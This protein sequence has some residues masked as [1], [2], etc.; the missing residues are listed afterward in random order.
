[1]IRLFSV[2]AAELRLAS[3]TRRRSR[4]AELENGKDELRLAQVVIRLCHTPP[5][6]R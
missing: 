3:T 5:L 1:M 2:C 6:G 4:T